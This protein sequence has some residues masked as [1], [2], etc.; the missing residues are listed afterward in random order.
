[1]NVLSQEYTWDAGRP[2]D[3]IL[4]TGQYGA[5]SRRVSRGGDTSSALKKSFFE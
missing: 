5:K 3:K 2:G 4:K 1:M